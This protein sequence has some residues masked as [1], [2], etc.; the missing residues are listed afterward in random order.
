[1]LQQAQIKH[2]HSAVT[3]QIRGIGIGKRSAGNGMDLLLQ[4][5]GIPYIA[6]WGAFLLDH[7]IAV[8]KIT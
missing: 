5:H 4:H 8:Q 2:I 7:V 6:K 1:M 3:V